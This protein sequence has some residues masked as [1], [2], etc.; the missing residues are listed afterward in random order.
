MIDLE[1]LI[2]QSRLSRFQ[3]FVAVLCA[4]VLLVDG[5]DTMAIGFVAPALIKAWHINRAAMTPVFA[6]GQVGLMLGSMVV[7]PLADRYGRRPV[8]IFS[9]FAFGLLSLATMSATS[10]GQLAVLRFLTGFG[11][12]GGMPNALALTSEYMPSRVRV[13]ATMVMFCGFSLGAALGGWAVAQLIA[14]HGWQAV[15]LIG[16]VVPLVLSVALA[17]LLPE[18][19]RYFAAAGTHPERLRRYVSRI[20]PHAD[21]ERRATYVIAEKKAKGFVVREL[22]ND[23]R[24]RLTLLLWTIT[25]MVLLDLNLLSNWM[26]VILHDSG[27]RL[28]TAATV[29]IGYQIGGAFGNLLLGRLVDRWSPFLVLAGT[30][31]IAFIGIVSLGFAGTNVVLLCA[32]IFLVGFCVIGGVGASDA[33]VATCY[34][35]GMRVTGLGWVIGVGRLGA[36]IGP[37]LGGLS[38]TMG[39]SATSFFAIGALPMLGAASAAWAI[40]VNA[41]QMQPTTSSMRGV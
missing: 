13:T 28:E 34:P 30:Y 14:Q 40:H 16:G 22:F 32:L 7:G 17:L 31:V 6:A 8:M 18:S 5:F 37:T 10:I 12:G 38:L 1:A 39:A 3:V 41:R 19:M 20:A 24:T 21:P 23:G 25:F 35:T 29:T 9:C 15:F 36:V 11:L 33:L 26:S 2:D 27:L 4:A